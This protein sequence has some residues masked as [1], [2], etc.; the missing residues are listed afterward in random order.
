MYKNR[1][2]K[3]SEISHY[4]IELK[5]THNHGA[6]VI[7]FH[8]QKYNVETARGATLPNIRNIWWSLVYDQIKLLCYHQQTV[9]ISSIASIDDAWSKIT[10]LIANGRSNAR[11]HYNSVTNM[12]KEPRRMSDIY[13]ACLQQEEETIEYSIYWGCTTLYEEW[14]VDSEKF[15]RILAGN[16]TRKK[17]YERCSDNTTNNTQDTIRTTLIYLMQPYDTSNS[18][19]LFS[20]AVLS[21]E[22]Y[23]MSTGMQRFV[24]IRARAV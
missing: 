24:R 4:Y 11:S 21:P 19:A 14:A 23:C 18:Y 17:K 10:L 3:L 9:H 22:W 12:S 2:S 15:Q 8:I 16:T 1:A 5:F 6:R 13:E 7:S 20:T